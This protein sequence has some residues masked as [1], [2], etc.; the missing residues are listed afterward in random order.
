VFV[1]AGHA[2]LS[3]QVHFASGDTAISLYTDGGTASFSGITTPDF[4]AP[5][6]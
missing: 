1:N 2:V 4:A 6:G 5:A 3:Q